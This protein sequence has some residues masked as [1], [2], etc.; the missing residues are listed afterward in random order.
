MNPDLQSIG[1]GDDPD[2]V[3]TVDE[4]D[5]QPHVVIADITRDDGW[6][7][8]SETAARCLDDWR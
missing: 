6:L 8:M 5:G 2:I 4:I 7:T 3:A 1:N